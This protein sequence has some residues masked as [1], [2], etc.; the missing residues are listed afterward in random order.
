MEDW[1]SVEDRLPEARQKVLL[2][3]PTDGF[4]IG[5]MYEDK[6]FYVGKP[7]PD[8]PT[9]WMPLPKQPKQPK[10]IN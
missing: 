1:I 5:Y 9:H 10:Q 8:R 3:S 4:N 7:Y 2:Y 6:R